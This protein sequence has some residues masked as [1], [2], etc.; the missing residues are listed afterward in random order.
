MKS[1]KIFNAATNLVI[2]IVLHVVVLTNRN[3]NMYP[4]IQSGSNTRAI[5]KVT[6]GELLRKQPMRKNHYIINTYILNL[7]LNVFTAGIEA[8]VVAGNKFLYYCVKEVCRL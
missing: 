1:G 7:L 6:S 4:F 8:F 2:F 5:Q 3:I